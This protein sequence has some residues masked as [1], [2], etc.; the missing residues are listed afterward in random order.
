MVNKPFHIFPL[1][2]KPALKS[3]A[4]F[5]IL[6][7]LACLIGLALLLPFQ[8]RHER[9]LYGVKAYDRWSEVPSDTLIQKA[10]ILGRSGEKIDSA[11]TFFAITANR[12]YEQGMKAA[13]A[14]NAVKA[15]NGL[16]CLFSIY[17][18]ENQIALGYHSEALRLAEKY[19][20]REQM[21]YICHNMGNAF[22]YSG[23]I[24]SFRFYSLQAQDYYRQSF[25]HAVDIGLWEVG[26][27]EYACL[28]GSILSEGNFADAAEDIQRFKQLKWPDSIPGYS[29]ARALTEGTALMNKGRRVAALAQFSCLP[30]YSH[31]SGIP[32]EGL[33]KECALIG[34]AR[35]YHQMGDKE[36]LE[37]CLRTM[38][39]TAH[40]E[41]DVN[42]KLYALRYRY[43]LCKQTG[44][45]AQ[46]NAVKMEYIQINDS[47]LSRGRKLFDSQRGYYAQLDN[48]STLARTQHHGP[49]ANTVVAL[50]LMAFGLGVLCVVL[51]RK[52]TTPASKSEKYA[53]SR[54][55][56]KE[57]KLLAVKIEEVLTQED[58]LKDPDFTICDLADRIDARHQYVSQVVNEVYGENFKTLLT[59]RRV[60][61]ACRMMEESPAGE[62]LKIEF[63]AASVGFKSR[64]SFTM[65]FKKIMKAS[66]SEYQQ[67]TAATK[68]NHT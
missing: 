61:L 27:T 62:V 5:V 55:T 11:V 13:D 50:L 14:M 48:I 42:L 6:A 39:R 53:G 34:L 54:L 26:L 57:K 58:I 59:E 60:E 52:R 63:L 16:G 2:G 20:F 31:T 44:D 23:D 33:F 40:D 56:L 7:V 24:N 66:P 67:Q 30:A 35:L 51:W 17:Y 9:I 12:Y 68:A 8:G 32:H 45:K 49:K 19:G 37:A 18:N 64:S 4:V 1:Q 38:Q 25:H 10:R 46:A 65:A 21:V 3:S 22:T 29:Y 43:L 41:V 28:M 47:D 15:L 36:Q